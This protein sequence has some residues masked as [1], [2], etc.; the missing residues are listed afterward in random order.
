MCSI[1]EHC[2]D[3]RWLPLFIAR[4]AL[5]DLIAGLRADAKW[6]QTA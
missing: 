5:C 4:S 1:P 2:I 3:V 6:V